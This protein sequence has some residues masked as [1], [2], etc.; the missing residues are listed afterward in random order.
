MPTPGTRSL[1]E[2]SLAKRLKRCLAENLLPTITQKV[3]LTALGSDS[4]ET[5][6]SVLSS[7]IPESG[8]ALKAYPKAT[9]A[10]R[11]RRFC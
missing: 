8:S 7:Q 10:M 9:Q 5:L 4:E 2:G 1:L 6:P 3:S 11:V